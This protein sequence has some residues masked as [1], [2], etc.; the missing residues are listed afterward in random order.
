MA[1]KHKVTVS[2]GPSHGRGTT[3]ERRAAQIAALATQQA[4]LKQEAAQRRAERGDHNGP[5]AKAAAARRTIS[6]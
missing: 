4:E 2:T 1:T 3:A 6:R 5:T